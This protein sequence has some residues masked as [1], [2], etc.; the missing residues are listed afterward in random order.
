MSFTFRIKHN[1][2]EFEFSSQDLQAIAAPIVAPAVVKPTP[3]AKTAKRGRGRPPGAKN[4]PK[5]VKPF[6][7][8]VN[9]QPL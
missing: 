4:K 5:V 3:V 6:I 2:T 9:T 8:T 1:G 7:P